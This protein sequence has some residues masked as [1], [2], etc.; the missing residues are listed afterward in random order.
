MRSIEPKGPY[1]LGGY[2]FG[3]TVAFEM[4]QQL[5]REGQEVALLVLLVPSTPLN[6]D[7]FPSPVPH[8]SG[9]AVDGEPFGIEIQR[10]FRNLGMLGP[11]KRIAYILAKTKRKITGTALTLSAPLRKMLKTVVCKI[12]LKS[13]YPLPL[14]LRSFYIL[15]IYRRALK[16]YVP[17]AYDGGTCHLHVQK[18]P[19]D[20]KI[21]KKLAL[22]GIESQEVGGSHSEV[23]NEPYLKTWAEELK[24]QLD[25]TQSRD[26][27]CV[28]N[29]KQNIGA[30]NH[31]TFDSV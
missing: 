3:G 6:C 16:K 20:S 15:E 12:Y 29:G 9:S 10:H 4:A 25:R 2:C 1:Y 28:A 14:S 11:K 30:S 31:G 23:L 22:R 17:K 8:G 24:D 5:R 18:N 26:G 27:R 7:Y 19:G 21:W 13:G